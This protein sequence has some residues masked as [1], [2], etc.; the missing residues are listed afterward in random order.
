M[1]K[2]TRNPPTGQSIAPLAPI[3]VLAVAILAGC[4]E[5]TGSVDLTMVNGQKTTAEQIDTFTVRG[6]I[7]DIADDHRELR[8]THEEIPGEMAAMTMSFRLLDPQELAGF[9]P[10]DVVQFVLWKRDFSSWISALEKLSPEEAGE[11]L[12]PDAPSFSEDGEPNE[13]PAEVSDASL[14]AIHAN[15]TNQD[16]AHVRLV[17]FRGHPVVLSMIFTSC[18]YACPMIVHDMKK[19]GAAMPEEIQES[20]Q[21]VLVSIDPER[22]TPEALKAFAE[23][24]HLQDGQWTL[25]RG[26]EDDVRLLAAALGVRYRKQADGQFAHT[27][28]VS[29]LDNAGEIVHQKSGTGNNDTDVETLQ[30]VLAVLQ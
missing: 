4:T 24:H 27:S 16:G 13:Q 14:F 10:G 1:H 12:L 7:D 19:L 17:D 28:L 20:L 9:A 8:I 6:R 30:E 11:L 2:A 18:S 22:D 5:S 15:W 26:S 23:A 3:I 25:L 21:Y 29:V